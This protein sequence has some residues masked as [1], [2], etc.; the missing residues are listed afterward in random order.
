MSEQ[1]TC[2]SGLQCTVRGLKT[3][4]A[5]ILAG[6]KGAKNT[7]AAVNKILTACVESVES[8]GPYKD[9]IDWDAVLAGDRYY[10]L[11]QI[12]KATLGS[13]YLF[14]TQCGVDGCN[15]RF[16]W[17]VDLDDMP[18][19]TFSA[20]ERAAFTNGNRF[21]TSLLDGTKVWFSLP[22]GA[23]EKRGIALKSQHP[24]S[25]ISLS[26][27]MRILEIEGVAS[28]DVRKYVSELGLGDANHL[29]EEFDS[30]DCGVDAT[31]EI[32]CPEC[33][34]LKDVSLPFDQAFFFPSQ[35]SR[36]KKRRDTLDA[37]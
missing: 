25:M 24:D 10:L 27:R 35:Q 8:Y 14:K 22:T 20:E 29:I 37:A 32:E 21:A 16:E 18:I 34:A 33:F 5:D 15:K 36:T 30:V 23:D 7:P 13:K 3:K 4:E 31:I 28:Q 1:I 17:E 12:R 11:L 26:L 6:V 19:T 9:P 2:P